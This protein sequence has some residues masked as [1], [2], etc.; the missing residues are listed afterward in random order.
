MADFKWLKRANKPKNTPSALASG[1]QANSI[2]R[3]SRILQL[4]RS[5]G[6]RATMD[7]LQREGATATAYTQSV[8]GEQLTASEGRPHPTNPSQSGHSRER[9]VKDKAITYTSTSSKKESKKTAFDSESQQDTA[10][11][12]A[13]NSSDGQAKAKAVLDGDSPREFITAGFSGEVYDVRKGAVH[14]TLTASG[15]KVGI[16]KAADGTLHFVTA[17]PTK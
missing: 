5:I 2:D 4:Q 9:H 17:Y 7:L 8:V 14:A 15:V 11:T 3:A 16:E 10:V 12:G 1:R 6:N 13:L